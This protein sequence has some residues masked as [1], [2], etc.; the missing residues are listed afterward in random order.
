MPQYGKVRVNKSNL[1]IKNT[2]YENVKIREAC[3]LQ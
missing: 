1:I 3:E 2:K